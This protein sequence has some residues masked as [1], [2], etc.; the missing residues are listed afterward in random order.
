M[1][2]RAPVRSSPDYFNRLWWTISRNV[3]GTPRA[4]DGRRSAEASDLEHGPKDHD[5]FGDIVQQRAG[6]DRGALAFRGGDESGRSGDP[7]SNHC[8]FDSR[9]RG[10]IDPGAVELL[11]HVF[12]DS[13][14]GHLARARAEHLAAAR[15]L[16]A[17][18]VGIFPPTL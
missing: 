18:E 10:C 13:I 16:N 4:R 12:P 9:I 11:E 6:D 8:P 3:R 17:V 7:S 14:C 1:S 2:R 5:R 15:F